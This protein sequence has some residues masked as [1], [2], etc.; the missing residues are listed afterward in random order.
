MCDQEA[1]H[2]TAARAEALEIES[3]S[4]MLSAFYGR[5]LEAAAKV[6][7]VEYARARASP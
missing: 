2:V 4:P 3:R 5:K 6:C 7:A 1:I